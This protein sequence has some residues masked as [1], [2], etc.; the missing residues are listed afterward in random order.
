M[1]LL[2]KLKSEITVILSTDFTI[3]HFPVSSTLD[4]FPLETFELCFSVVLGNPSLMS[5]VILI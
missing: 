5:L 1:I 3:E 2:F 4:V